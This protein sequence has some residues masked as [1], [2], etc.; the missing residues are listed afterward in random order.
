MCRGKAPHSFTLC[1]TACGA[2]AHMLTLHQRQQE[3]SDVHTVTYASSHI[4]R[5]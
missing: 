5:F 4:C 2:A 1:L 3:V